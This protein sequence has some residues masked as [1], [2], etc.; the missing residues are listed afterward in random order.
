ME[1]S[2]ADFQAIFLIFSTKI[3]L[4]YVSG[5]TDVYSRKLIY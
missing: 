5:I 3:E 4:I 1:K 2:E